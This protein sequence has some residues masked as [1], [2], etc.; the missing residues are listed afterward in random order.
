MNAADVPAEM[1]GADVRCASARE[2]EVEVAHCH[3]TP[4]RNE[5]EAR[6]ESRS[7]KRPTRIS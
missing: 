3:E 6:T 2:V 4:L 5:I 7:A 1:I